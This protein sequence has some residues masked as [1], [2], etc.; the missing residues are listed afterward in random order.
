MKGLL[1]ATGMRRSLGMLLALVAVA[2][3]FMPGVLPPPTRVAAARTPPLQLGPFTKVRTLFS[4]LRKSVKSEPETVES[5][6]A[7]VA[8]EMLKISNDGAPT[9]A[10]IEEYCRDPESSGCDIE[11]VE[12]LMAEA[13][14]TECLLAHHALHMAACQG[15][16]CAGGQDEEKSEC[17]RADAQRP[18]QGAR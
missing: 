5:G 9:A 14:A 4:T 17:D 2:R 15:S 6:P 12:A 18:R 3:G 1:R 7:T 8:S 16:T 10:E 13:R 11:M